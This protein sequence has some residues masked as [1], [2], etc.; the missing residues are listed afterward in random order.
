M[1]DKARNKEWANSYQANENKNVINVGI[2]LPD[3]MELKVKW[4]GKKKA[5]ELNSSPKMAWSKRSSC[6]FNS[7]LMSKPVL[8]ATVQYFLHIRICLPQVSTWISQSDPSH[9]LTDPLYNS[10]YLVPEPALFSTF[11]KQINDLQTGYKVRPLRTRL[12]FSLIESL[13]SQ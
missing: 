6:N 8:S 13:I 11:W 10:P 1:S 12:D 2:L 5:K 3:E 9:N 4:G 7:A